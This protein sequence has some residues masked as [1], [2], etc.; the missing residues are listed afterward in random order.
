MRPAVLGLVED[1]VARQLNA[2]E[3]EKPSEEQEAEAT[4]IRGT[5]ASTFDEMH[6]QGCAAK[7][8]AACAELASPY[9]DGSA[10]E[11][12][13]MA[14]DL[15]LFQ[16]GCEGGFAVACDGLGL[17][18]EVGRGVD[19]DEAKALEL[20]ARACDGGASD[21]CS[22]KTRL[23]WAIQKRQACDGGDLHACFEIA[24]PAYQG[25][26]AADAATYKQVCEAQSGFEEKQVIKAC[27]ELA[28]CHCHGWCGQ[29][30]DGS[31]AV[32]YYTRAC[33]AGESDGCYDLGKMLEYG[34]CG[35]TPDVD[36]AKSYY[37]RACELS[38]YSYACEKK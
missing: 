32:T 31:L 4:E 8:A 36:A 30:T 23:E 29:A 2:K 17:M 15:E 14:R 35:T 21:G 18:R 27:M 22:D 33:D 10:R 24:R 38:S 19:K 1:E 28:Q 25:A 34:E 11:P 37:A 16:K 9:R 12:E 13:A 7:D 26:S 20:Y 5:L 6:R 3:A